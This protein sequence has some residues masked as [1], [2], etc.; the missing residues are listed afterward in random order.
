[1][2][3]SFL[4]RV[5]EFLKPVFA[6]W[7]YL[8]VFAGVFLESFFLTSWAAPG[9]VILLLGAFYSASGELNPFLVSITAYAAATVG[10]LFAYYMG[11][12]GG[13]RL[14]H[15]YSGSRKVRDNLSRSGEYFL[16]YGGRTLLFG[17]WVAGIKAFI[18][19]MAGVG[20]MPAAKFLGYTLAGNLLWTGGVFAAG[21]FF[22]ESW[23]YIDRALSYLGWGLLLIVALVFL[24][25]FARRRSKA[26]AE[27]GSPPSSDEG[28]GEGG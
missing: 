13:H 18:P 12:R 25:V 6:Y 22:G 16:R 14:L 20:D 9:T 3:G 7:G 15:R 8:V 28:T 19:I 10:D 11:V 4:E 24:L 27:A 21:Y 26:R 5:I 17:K 23:R 2:A 1:L